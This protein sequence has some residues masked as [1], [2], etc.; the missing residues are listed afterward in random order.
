MWRCRIGSLVQALSVEGINLPADVVQRG[1]DSFIFHTTEETVTLAAPYREMRIATVYR[2]AGP[3]G[4][5]SPRWRSF[6][7][8][9]LGLASSKGARVVREKVTDITWK[10]GKPEIHWSPDQC[11]VYDL[12]AGAVGVKMPNPD[13]FEKLGTG[14]HKPGTR[15]TSNT[16]YELGSGYITSKLGNSMHAFLLDLPSLDFAALIPK[17]IT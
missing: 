3:K 14:Y 2:G 7:G 17:V 4:N 12:V 9:L 16:E 15:K 10:E 1:I 8:Y 5:K 11:Q 6:D 13:F